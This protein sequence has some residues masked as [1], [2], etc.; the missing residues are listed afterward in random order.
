MFK[1]Y[2]IKNFCTQKIKKQKFQKKIQ[3][4]ILQKVFL[5]KLKFF[6]FL[7]NSWRNWI[8]AKKISKF[9]EMTYLWGTL[10]VYFAKYLIPPNHRQT[11]RI[12]QM[13]QKRL[14]FVIVDYFLV[15]LHVLSIQT[16]WRNSW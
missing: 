14:I 10:R 2:S 12:R 6:N 16:L 9:S 8:W 5:E 4:Q 7:K 15:S 1:N 3:K 11:Q 13:L